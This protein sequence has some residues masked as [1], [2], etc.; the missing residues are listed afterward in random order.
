MKF[1]DISRAVLR[2]R[3][4]PTEI[5]GSNINTDLIEHRREDGITLAACPICAMPESSRKFCE[6][7]GMASC[8]DAVVVTVDG[9]CRNN[10]KPNARAAIGV[11]V[12]PQC[13]YNHRQLLHAVTTNQV[14]EL[15]ASLMGLEK[16]KELMLSGE[17]EHGLK[18]LIIKSDSAYLVNAVT[19][20]IY[21]WEFSGYK[22]FRGPRVDNAVLL[23]ELLAKTMELERC[24]VEVMFWQ[25]PREMNRQEGALANAALNA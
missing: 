12:G 18:H 4:I 25:V 23:G 3:F 1:S 2:R 7:G 10:G 11:F 17:L 8:G 16:A 20:W 15:R 5:Y 9:A 24:N 19:D 22:N 13:S 14:A 6:C 21:H